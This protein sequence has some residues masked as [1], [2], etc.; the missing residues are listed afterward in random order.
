MDSGE[1]I[2]HTNGDDHP[3]LVQ[4]A[5]AHAQ[6]ETIHPLADGNGRTGRALIH[7][8]LRRRGLEPWPVP[9]NLTLISVDNRD[10]AR[11]IVDDAA[12]LRFLYEPLGFRRRGPDSDAAMPPMCCPGVERF[13]DTSER[14]GSAWTTNLLRFVT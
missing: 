13:I 10:R 9:P 7:V 6:F 11:A 2:V 5:I 1:S 3:A 12:S 4:A 8:I 14:Y